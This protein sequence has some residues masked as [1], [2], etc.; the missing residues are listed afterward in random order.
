MVYRG[1]SHFSGAFQRGEAT[2]PVASLAGQSNLGI[3]QRRRKYR[4]R[5]RLDTMPQL[6]N[7]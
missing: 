5:S 4:E 7:L 1:L 6:L 3:V 2:D